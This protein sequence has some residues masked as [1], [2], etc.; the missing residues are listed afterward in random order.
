[1]E[2]PRGLAYHFSSDLSF[3]L[4]SSTSPLPTSSSWVATC[5]RLSLWFIPYGSATSILWEPRSPFQKMVRRDKILCCGLWDHPTTKCCPSVPASFQTRSYTPRAPAP[6][7]ACASL[8]VVPATH[9]SPRDLGL[10]SLLISFWQK[11][12][13]FWDLFHSVHTEWWKPLLWRPD[14]CWRK[15]SGPLT[16]S[17]ETRFQSRFGLWNPLSHSNV[18]I[19]INQLMGSVGVSGPMYKTVSAG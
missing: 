18:C 8:H 19:M 1:M 5:L 16:G 10:L 3:L 13:L 11:T 7:P 14:H 2:H 15:S 12:L 17:G 6:P 9:H 4:F